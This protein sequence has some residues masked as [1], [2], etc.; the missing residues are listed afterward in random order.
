MSAATTTIIL[1][2]QQQEEVKKHL[3]EAGAPLSKRLA[4]Y[5]VREL[6]K[7]KAIVEAQ[8]GLWYLD[9][10]RNR[11]SQKAQF[12]AGAAVIVGLVVVIAAV[13][14]VAVAVGMNL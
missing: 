2:M 4:S 11:A 7:R 10:A 14:A 1:L 8:P 9:E 12:K 3:R 5:A 6:S 13:I